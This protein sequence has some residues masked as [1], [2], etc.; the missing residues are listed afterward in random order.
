MLFC[1]SE[2]NPLTIPKHVAIIMDG[3]GRWAKARNQPIILGHRAGAET[4]RKITEHAAQLG[5]KYLTLYTFSSEN[6]LRSQSWIDEL[7]GLMRW[8]LKN[9]IKSLSNNGVRL[10]IIGQRELLPQDIQDLIDQAEKMTENNS[11]ITLILALSYGSRNEITHALQQIA[12]KIEEKKLFPQDINAQL[13]ENHLYTTGIPDP[14]L[15]IRTSGEQR[16]SNYLLWQIAYTELVFVPTFWP[17][18]NSVEFGRAIQIFQTR[19]R[20]YGV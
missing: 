2:I 4:A 17:D 18:F 12:F 5:I 14:D 9:E 7:M 16:L 20:R 6:W 3:N 11:K 10:R 1:V 15:L 19:Q 13:I 8:Y